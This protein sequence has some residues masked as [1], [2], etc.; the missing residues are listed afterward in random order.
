MKLKNCPI[1]RCA[2]CNNNLF[3]NGVLAKCYLTGREFTKQDCLNE[4]FPEDCQ[5]ED[6]ES[7]E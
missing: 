1:S 3:G 2:D 5:L 4:G 6:R 7:H